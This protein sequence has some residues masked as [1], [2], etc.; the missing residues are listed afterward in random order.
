MG[1][2]SDIHYNAIMRFLT[3]RMY[4]IIVILC[5]LVAILFFILETQTGAR[6]TLTISSKLVPGKLIFNGVHGKLVGTLTIDQMIYQKQQ[7]KI[8]AENIQLRWNPK[9]LLISKLA[10]NKLYADNITIN[11][12]PIAETPVKGNATKFKILPIH[13]PLALQLQ[14]IKFTHITITHKDFPKPAVI[15]SLAIKLYTNHSHIKH[16]DITLQAPSALLEIHGQLYKKYDLS[17]N[18]NIKNLS[19]L[20]PKASGSITSQGRITGNKNNPKIHA[21]TKIANFKFNTNTIDKLQSTIN[22]DLAANQTSQVHFYATNMNFNQYSI[23][24]IQLYGKATQTQQ[25]G[26]RTINIDVNFSPTTISLPAEYQVH[27]FTLQQG[28]LHASF[29]NKKIHMSLQNANAIIPSLNLQLTNIQINADGNTK[30]L[31]YTVQLTSGDGKLNLTGTTVLNE[32]KF[33]TKITINGK[34]ITVSNTNT[35]QIYASPD[36][37]LLI[38]SKRLDANGSITIPKANIQPNDF[39]NTVTLPTDVVFIDKRYQNMFIDQDTFEVYCNIKLI[40]GNQIKI[41][42]MGLTGKLIG[43]IEIQEQPQGTTAVGTLQIKDGSYDVYGQPLTIKSGSLIYSGEPIDNPL[44]DITA[45]REFRST[46]STTAFTGVSGL[47]VGAHIQGMLNNP[48]TSLFSDPAGLSNEDILSYMV[49]GQPVTQVGTDKLSLLLRA[50][51]AINLGSSASSITN[52]TDSIRSKLGLS[53]LGIETES[54]FEDGKNKGTSSTTSLA[55]GRYLSPSLY[56]GYSL[57]LLDQVSIYRVRYKL[58]KQLYIQTEGNHLG[59][60]ADLLYS[61]EK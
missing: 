9:D 35:I 34:N 60:G 38:S 44:I 12:P 46:N 45:V 57:S 25:K 11:L 41:N 52:V 59:M 55:L 1:L 22:L 4:S 18:I 10:I 31:D 30:K 37:E 50:A 43:Q 7:T 14:D 13:F 15:N 28:K 58:W 39:S 36:L 6:W 48:Q 3:N 20:L 21:I 33:A 49:I 56:L 51:Q 29:H 32:P 23:D 17:W 5:A 61:S 40:L 19:D 26:K 16:A 27:T 42:A 54:T 24:K 47:T 2:I 53:D 8:T